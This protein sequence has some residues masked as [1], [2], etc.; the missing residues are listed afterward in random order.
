[1][2][3]LHSGKKGKSGTKRPKTNEIPA[4]VKMTKEEIQNIILKS[5]REGMAPSKIGLMLRDQYGVPNLSSILGSSVSA[6]MRK[7]K[8]ASEYPEDLLNL[9]KKAVRM[10]EHLKGKGNDTLNGVKLNHV[11]SKIQRLVK[12]YIEKGRLPQNWKY[13]REKAALI[14]K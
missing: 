11:E 8:V 3:R 7:E 6:F 14:V 13:E 4:W 2:A 9:I 5:A 1:M 12:Y 10:N